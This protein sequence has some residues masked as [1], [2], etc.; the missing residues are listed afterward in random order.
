MLI[1]A[2]EDAFTYFIVWENRIDE[3][4]FLADRTGLVDLTHLLVD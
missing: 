4:L 1:C 2:S 3:P